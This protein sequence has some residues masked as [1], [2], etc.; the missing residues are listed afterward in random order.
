MKVVSLYSG[1][2][3]LD[4]GFVQAGS[5]VLWAID[6]DE[7]AVETYRTNLGDH[8]ACG[9]LPSI[10]PPSDLKPDVVI[11]GPPCQG[12]SVI[13]Q[14]NPDDE[15]SEHV[16]NFFNVVESFKPR[17]FVMENVKALAISPRWSSVRD[18]LLDRYRSLGYS[19][20]IFILNASHYGVP[21]A[22]ERMFMI[23]LQDRVPQHPVS[24]MNGHSVNVRDALSDLPKYG[25]LGNDDIS[26]VRV[27]PANIPVVR[28][29][30]YKGS[31]LF[32]GSGRTLDLD[33]PAKTLTASGGNSLPIID[34]LELE[35][36]ADPWVVEY[37]QYL[38]NKGLAIDEA[39]A[40]MRRITVQE[41]A[42]LQTF[43]RDWTWSGPQSSR[44]RQIG[45]A[46]PPR[47]AEAVARSVRQSL[48]G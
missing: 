16:D 23:G 1:A 8:I 19:T 27:V 29:S 26:K 7:R 9:S 20:K 15:R 34:Q 31:L 5:D 43:P 40:R 39:P 28:G 21:Q 25:S 42:A 2:G 22:R 17:A 24:I 18:R 48:D 11:G 41:F 10:S 37:Y 3:G 14:M 38:K 36:G 35:E 30:A 47:L 46:V 4:L 33:A 32:N 45:N 12:F 44:Y 6:N 13:G